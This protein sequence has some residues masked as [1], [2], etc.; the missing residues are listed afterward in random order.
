MTNAQD[1]FLLTCHIKASFLFIKLIPVA[2]S[3][4]LQEWDEEVN[5]V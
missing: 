2:H 4:D 1:P 5:E 3:E